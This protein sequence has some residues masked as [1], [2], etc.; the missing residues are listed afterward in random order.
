MSRLDDI[1]TGCVIR[2]PYLWARE[3]S[4]GETEGRKPRPTVVGLRLKRGRDDCLIL[5]PITSQ[6][7]LPG[8]DSIEIPDTEKR[9]AGLDTDKRLWIILDEYNCDEV[10]RSWYLEP[11]PPLG[12]FSRAFI[13]PVMQRFSA[14]IA[15]KTQIR[16][17]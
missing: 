11:V 9:R 12:Q 15:G 10:A 13:L 8:R 6:P 16:R 17:R 3:S 1:R 4:A 14:A 7:P 2:Y 5:L